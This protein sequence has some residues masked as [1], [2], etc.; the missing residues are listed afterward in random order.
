M[1]SDFSRPVY[2]FLHLKRMMVSG[3]DGSNRDRLFDH[4]ARCRLPGS[5]QAPARQ[6]QVVSVAHFEC[7]GFSLVLE[8]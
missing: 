4:A 6:A 2:G 5:G 8:F 3:D 7:D 1:T